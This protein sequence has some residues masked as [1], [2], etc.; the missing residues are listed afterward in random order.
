MSAQSLT[1]TNRAAYWSGGQSFNE[2][3]RKPL[4]IPLVVIVPHE[5][6]ERSAQ[7]PFTQRHDPIQA[8][9]LDRPH[10]SLRIGVA[11]GGTRR[12]MRTPAIAR[13]VGA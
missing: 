12:T 9:F 13:G 6:C 3:V 8:L 1:P 5:L 11:F 10:E 7:M 4:V 2:I